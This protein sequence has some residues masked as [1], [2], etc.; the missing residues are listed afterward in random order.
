MSEREAKVLRDK[1][2]ERERGGILSPGRQNLEK[3]FFLLPLSPTPTRKPVETTVPLENVYIG[4]KFVGYFS[5]FQMN[6][7]HHFHLQLHHPW[8]SLARAREHLPFN[9]GV[10][11]YSASLSLSETT[12]HLRKGNSPGTFIN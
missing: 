2:K 9:Q 3:F 7:S 4:K 10:K 6:L 11:S 8:F 1:E 5:H 12:F